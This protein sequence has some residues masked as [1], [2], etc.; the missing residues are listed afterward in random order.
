MRTILLISGAVG[1]VLGYLMQRAVKDLAN[2]SPKPILRMELVRARADVEKILGQNEAHRDGMRR[3]QYLDFGFIPVYVVL[4]GAT[5]FAIAGQSGWRQAAIAA[6]V[7]IVAAGV[8]DVFEDLGI[9]KAIGGNPPNR[10]RLFALLKWG[11]FGLTVVL[12]GAMLAAR[13]GSMSHI[14]SWIYVGCGLVALAGG[15]WCVKA[16][17]GQADAEIETATTAAVFGV[18]VLF[19]SSLIESWRTA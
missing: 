10:V 18:F 8:F 3:A 16:V 4:L 13:A 12:Q 9:L 11:L 5:G 2:L 1:L 15:A 19:V 14:P 6:L 17:L 7:V